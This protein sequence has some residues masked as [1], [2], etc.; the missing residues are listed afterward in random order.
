MVGSSSPSL[1]FLR[2]YDAVLLV[3][4]GYQRFFKLLMR[5]Y[6]YLYLYYYMSITMIRW[7]SL[8]MD[9]WILGFGILLVLCELIVRTSVI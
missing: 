5:L 1:S 9:S 3:L 2:F 4:F 8:F 7:L 6:L